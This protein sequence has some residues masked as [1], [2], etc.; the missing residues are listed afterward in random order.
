MRKSTLFVLAIFFA[1]NVFGQYSQ[2]QTMGTAN[3]LVSVP[4]NGG[5]RAALINRTFTDTTAA[6]SHPISTYP[7]A[8]I[9]T[10]GDGNMWVRNYLATGW[11][12]L[13]GGTSPSGSF[14]RIGGN[15]FPVSAPTRDIGTDATY[16]GAVGLMTNGVV[17]AI[18]PNGG[19]L[20]SNDTSSNKIFTINPSTKEWG[21]T[22]W[23]NGSLS[24]PTAY[25][26]QFTPNN[27]VVNFSSNSFYNNVLS[28][29]L[30]SSTVWNDGTGLIVNS[31][32]SGSLT[33]SNLKANSYGINTS[34]QYTQRLVFKILDSTTTVNIGIGTDNSQAISPTTTMSYISGTIGVSPF[35]LINWCNA[36]FTFIDSVSIS[37]G[38]IVELV[39][40]SKNDST[41]VKFRNLTNNKYLELKR[42]LTSASSSALPR[43]G[44]PSIFIKNGHFKLLEYDFS[45]PD[46]QYN[47][48]GNS[49]A[50]G[51]NATKFDTSHVYRLLR[52]A[53]AK[54]S[55][56]CSP[57]STT[58]DYLS[59]SSQVL[60]M[61]NKVVFLDGLMGNDGQANNSYDTAKA[62]YSRLVSSLRANGNTVVHI[63][64]SYR[65]TFT[66]GQPWSFFY[67]LNQW[68]DTAYGTTD[69]VVHLDTLTS[70]DL[71]DG[72][73]P[74]DAGHR[75][76]YNSILRNL[77]EYFG[78]TEAT[79]AEISRIYNPYKGQQIFNTDSSKIV[80]WD[81]SNWTTVGGSGGGSSGITVGATTITSGTNTRVGFNDGGVYGEDGGLAYDKTTDILSI[82]V[83]ANVP[84]I[85]GGTGTTSDLNLKTTT[86]VG[87]TGA[88]MH[89]L[90][91]NNGGTE[92]M[93]ILNSGAIGFNS[94]SPVSKY[95]F[96]LPVGT[97]PSTT[98]TTDHFVIGEPGGTG[99]GLGIMRHN[100]TNAV[101]L[102]SVAPNVAW[103]PLE[104]YFSSSAFYGSGSNLG[105]SIAATGNVG[106][107][108][109]TSTDALNISGSL[110]M[111]SGRHKTAQ[112]ADVA[113]AAG[114]IALGTDGN[115][116]EI[117]GTAAITLI[118]NVSWQ[119]GSE[120]TLL[121]TSTATLTD[122]TANSGTDIGM[123]LAGN[124][125]FTASAGATLTLILSEIG[126]TQRWR[127]KCRSVN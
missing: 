31:A 76:M 35:Y 104:F 117:T 92:A 64:I 32:Y 9:G 50:A 46:F 72:V 93:S 90:V 19:V 13:G 106:I 69:R 83:A 101:R 44:Y 56:F 17:R 45:I 100:G 122:G 84:T 59:S 79:T 4:A 119:N 102:Y 95:N 1:A 34:S 48:I 28:N 71:S 16:G 87:T 114:A 86:G 33:L 25:F 124:T 36:S 47:F 37:I 26:T 96:Y 20:L 85:Y 107:K 7:F 115:S 27:Y 126:G 121:F 118:S 109:T 14:W 54:S 74:N 21:Y 91:G 49:I 89:F 70:A 75:I 38:D 127:E 53:G 58:I 125:N 97:A 52:K 43:N 41:L 55:L 5:L 8:Q 81:G 88:D 73:H 11:V 120:V 30:Q 65:S 110:S 39:L 98:W 2:N 116:F 62:R 66:G 40:E 77:P 82:G 103:N 15:M 108:T 24:T 57:S 51:N 123:E 111:I 78:Q 18:V 94:N 3:T 42:G 99:A 23:N 105:I 6:N 12:L 67:A 22:N 60:S 61:R 112:G 10:T 80:Y 68:L 113:S 29:N 63:D